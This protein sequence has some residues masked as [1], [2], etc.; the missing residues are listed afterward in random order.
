MVL[1]MLSP[2]QRL[3]ASLAITVLA[4]VGAWALIRFLSPDPPRV[5]Q[6]ST[7]APDGAYHQFALK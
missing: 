7:G 6:M 2:R 4:A 1:P 5:V 3:L